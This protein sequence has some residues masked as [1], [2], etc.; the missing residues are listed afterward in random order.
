MQ[1]L[2]LCLP[3]QSANQFKPKNVANKIGPL[4]TITGKAD[5]YNIIMESL[6][7]VFDGG[8]DRDSCQACRSSYDYRKMGCHNMQNIS[9]L[10]KHIH[11][12]KNLP[13]LTPPTLYQPI[14]LANKISVLYSCFFSFFLKKKTVKP[15]S[16]SG[17]MLC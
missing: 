8:A 16:I 9:A 15:T 17:R 12:F 5:F 14:Y 6:S 4:Q 3:N 10:H 11:V 13:C 7:G 1:L 2:S